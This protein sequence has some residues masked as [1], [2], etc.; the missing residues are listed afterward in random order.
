MKRL[1]MAGSL[2]LAALCVGVAVAPLHGEAPGKAFAH[3]VYFTLKDSTPETR[4]ALV[5]AC[6]EYLSGHDGTVLFAAGTRAPEMKRDVND[7]EFDVSLHI[8]FEDEVAH[9]AY[10]EHPRHQEFIAQ[11]NANWKTVRVFDSRVATVP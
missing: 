4:Q 7:T 11:M 5:D 3:D 6:Q 2:G 8:Y 1:L 9:A 10:Q